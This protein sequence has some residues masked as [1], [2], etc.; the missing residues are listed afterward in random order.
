MPPT[1]TWE[2]PQ[3]VDEVAPH[4]LPSGSIDDV[5][6]LHEPE[7]RY[8]DTVVQ[9]Q[10]NSLRQRV[11]EKLGV[12]K[13]GNVLRT[14]KVDYQESETTYQK[15]ITVASGIGVLAVEAVGPT[16]A[17]TILVPMIAIEVLQNTGSVL[18]VGLVTGA[19]FGAWALSSAVILNNGVNR[20]PR[21]IKEAREN[22]PSFLEHFS[23][24]LPGL[25]SKKDAD[26]RRLALARYIGNQALTHVRR[27][28][29]AFG[30]GIAPFIVTAG[31]KDQ[32]KSERRRLCAKVGIDSGIMVGLMSAGLAQ[33]IIKIGDK[34]PELAQRIQDNASSA[35]LWYGVAAVLMAGE[36][37]N[38]KRKAKKEPKLQLAS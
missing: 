13:F 4:V 18:K 3:S 6:E 22:F 9:E 14:V 5:P 37:L 15:V 10:E 20:Y 2:F 21:T 7:G 25:E 30:I 27:G 16:K 26:P 34:H 36:W 17:P 24:A 1:S 12:K 19:A 31:M 33:T 35:K 23:N 29:T 28:I 38:N 11:A 8:E 32:S